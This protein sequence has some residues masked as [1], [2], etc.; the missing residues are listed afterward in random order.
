MKTTIAFAL[1]FAFAT[2]FTSAGETSAVQLTRDQFNLM[3]DTVDEL[4]ELAEK[5]DALRTKLRNRRD[6]LKEVAEAKVE[7]EPKQEKPFDTTPLKAEIPKG[8][9]LYFTAAWCGPC[10]TNVK[11]TMAVLKSEGWTMG[12]YSPSADVNFKMVDWDKFAPSRAL[13]PEQ[14]KQFGV[15]G[16]ILILPTFV[17][18]EDGVEVARHEGVLEKQGIIDLYIGDKRRRPPKKE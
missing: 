8:H 2:G 18:I 14:K 10:Q 4:D 3:R 12:D 17:K 7:A 15:K 9:M 1:L 5:L 16:D 6:E 13:T 11:P